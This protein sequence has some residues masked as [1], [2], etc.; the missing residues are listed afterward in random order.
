MFHSP[1]Y[2]ASP[3][4]G[5]F[6]RGAPSPCPR[7]PAP[8]NPLRAAFVG[9]LCGLLLRGLHAARWAAGGAP[10]APAPFSPLP[11]GAQARPLA[12]AGC[13]GGLLYSRPSWLGPLSLP[14]AQ[15][16]PHALSC[17][18]GFSAAR[19]V[20]LSLVVSELARF[21]RADL[22]WADLGVGF[23]VPFAAGA[24]APATDKNP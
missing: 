22:S 8:P 11:V 10:I 7:R 19:S 3:L 20:R 1:L 12:F 18:L 16:R 14:S 23:W 24:G 13:F 9:C 17:P 6:R 5:A 21:A 15:A 4:G 2:L